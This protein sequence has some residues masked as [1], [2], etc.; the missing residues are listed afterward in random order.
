VNTG[1]EGAGPSELRLL[2]GWVAGLVL[3]VVCGWGLLY[4]TFYLTRSLHLKDPELPFGLAALLSLGLFLILER[5]F[6][7]SRLMGLRI[8][9]DSAGWKSA[10]WLWLLGV[11]GLLF[12]S[13]GP[14]QAATAAPGVRAGKSRPQPEKQQ[15]D[16]TREVVET[17]VFVVVLVLLLKSFVA[18]AFVI[19]TGSMAQTLWGYQKVVTCPQCGHEFPVNCSS[20][21]DPSEGPATHVFAC[22][23]PNCRQH[24]WLRPPGGPLTEPPPEW[25]AEH[26]GWVQVPDPGWSSGDRVLVAKSDYDLLKS[27]ERSDVVVFKF[28][29]NR[30]FPRS[31]PQK[32]HVP[33]NYIKR[34]IGLPGETV[35]IH[36]GKIYILPADKSPTYPEDREA[37]PAQLWQHRFMHTNYPATQDLFTKKAFHILRKKPE[38]MLA[39]KRLVYD[40]DHPARDLMDRPRWFGDEGSGWEAD[41]AHGF[42]HTGRSSTDSG[43]GTTQWLRYHHLLRDQDRPS[44]ITDFM[45]YNTWE[46]GPHT[47]PGENWVGDLILECEVT[48]DQPQGGLVLELS[49]GTDRFQARW[50]LPQGTCTLVRINANGK[51]EKLA[52]KETTL[53]GPGTYRLRLANVDEKLTLWVDNQLPF[54]E[55]GVPYSAPDSEGATEEN[56]LKRPASIGVSGAGVRV[57]KVK[58]WRDTYYTA[59]QESAVSRSD[60]PGFEPARP[61]T[62]KWDRLQVLTMYVQPGHYLCLGDNSP[63]SSDGRSWG[64]VPRRLMLGRAVLVY[65]PFGRAGRIK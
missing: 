41:G 39:M 25:V 4:L 52:S 50:D 42:R 2:A 38:T 62:W 63:E 7:L 21:V 23:C 35:A 12:R 46:G 17:V 53:T 22:T 34:L 36:A 5:K 49:R 28:P 60:V 65:Y 10:F 1:P 3:V 9:P 44:L 32:N 37:P 55:D 57:A 11:P 43:G 59:S 19:P 6:W 16:S 54:G 20:E 29:G 45:A 58:L 18:E 15:A 47:L 51:P 27:P 30:D 56:D 33:M 64:T 61:D 14:A 24:I 40:N 31:G 8:D 13:T 26:P 48:V